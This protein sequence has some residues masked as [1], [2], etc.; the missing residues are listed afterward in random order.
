MALLDSDY[1]AIPD[2]L[3]QCPHLEKIIINSK[4]MM[5]V[6]ILDYDSSGDADCDGITD[7]R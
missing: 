6:L 5:V 1:D 3:D 2:H 7:D 4:M